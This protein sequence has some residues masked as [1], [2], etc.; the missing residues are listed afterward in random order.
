MLL[1]RGFKAPSLPTKHKMALIIAIT[2]RSKME[3]EVITFKAP[4]GLEMPEGIK[5]GDTFEVMA[6][7]A[8]G[9]EGELYLKEIDGLPVST[10]SEDEEVEAEAENDGGFLEAMDRRMTESE[11]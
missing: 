1:G 3:K 5:S 9:E 11:E 8:L 10:E 6:T 4:E 2:E 7:V